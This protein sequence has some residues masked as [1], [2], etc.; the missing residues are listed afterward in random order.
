LGA[1]SEGNVSE[2]LCMILSQ[3]Y[4]GKDKLSIALL[5]IPRGMTS[6]LCFSRFLVFRS[7]LIYMAHG[8]ILP[9]A[10]VV[11]SFLIFGFVPPNLLIVF[12]LHFPLHVHM[13]HLLYISVTYPE[14]T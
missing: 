8:T 2:F 14:C 13:T 9:I 11:I 3:Y 4:G 7:Q 5:C 10:V 1:R 6:R 12:R